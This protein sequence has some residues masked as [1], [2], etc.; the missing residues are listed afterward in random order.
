MTTFVCHVPDDRV[1]NHPT[2]EVLLT[3]TRTP[4]LV[5]TAHEEGRLPIEV[6]AHPGCHSFAWHDGNEVRVYVDR[7]FVVALLVEKDADYW[8]P[9]CVEPVSEV[10]A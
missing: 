9:L 4:E 2:T 7:G 1:D 8:P 6:T 10:A 5:V 3:I